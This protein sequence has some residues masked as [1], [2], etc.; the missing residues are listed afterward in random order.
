MSIFQDIFIQTQKILVFDKEAISQFVANNFELFLTDLS[1]EK[2]ICLFDNFFS[3]FLQFTEKQDNPFVSSL[4]QYMK[5]MSFLKYPIFFKVFKCLNFN[6]EHTIIKQ[7]LYE[8]VHLSL[9]EFLRLQKNLPDFNFFDNSLDIIQANYSN[10][11]NISAC[12]NIIETSSNIYELFNDNFGPNFKKFNTIDIYTFTVLC[13]NC[14][15]DFWY[16]MDGSVVASV[17]NRFDEIPEI[18]VSEGVFEKFQKAQLCLFFEEVE[19]C[20][21]EKSFDLLKNTNY[22]KY[23]DQMLFKLQQNHQTQDEEEYSEHSDDYIDVYEFTTPLISDNLSILE[24][25]LHYRFKNIHLLQSALIHRS[26]QRKMNTSANNQRLEYLGDAVLDLLLAEYF[27][28]RHPKSD[29]GILSK[30]RA[31]MANGDTLASISSLISLETFVLKGDQDFIPNKD[32]SKV[33]A[34]ALE[35]VFGAIWLD[36]S[37]SAAQNVFQFV[38]IPAIESLNIFP[39]LRRENSKSLLQEYTQKVGLELP[40]YE[41]VSKSGLDHLPRFTCKV[42]VLGKDYFGEGTSKKIAEK[43]AADQA[44]DFLGL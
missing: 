1:Y 23:L 42:C 28:L 16:Q 27:F 44:L 39:S 4:F 35:A 32:V 20:I 36:G 30:L 3:I 9:E 19:E 11:G 12:V 18:M 25:K 43:R 8:G 31:F 2:L 7:M 21:L 17:I 41:M 13:Q 37:F 29:E 15:F 24:D 10:F 22:T 33:Y 5:E 14:S 34:D 40:I 26:F 38:V 6:Y